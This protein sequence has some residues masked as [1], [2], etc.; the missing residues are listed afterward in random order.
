L[1]EDDTGTGN[2]AGRSEMTAVPVDSEGSVE[3][4]M[5]HDAKVLTLIEYN[6]AAFRELMVDCLLD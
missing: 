2:V 1:I 6:L 5:S 4:N 3:L